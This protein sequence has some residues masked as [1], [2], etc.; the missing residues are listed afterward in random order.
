[1]EK[2]IAE[3]EIRSQLFGWGDPEV[4]NT[5]NLISS[6]LS[7]TGRGGIA[8]RSLKASLRRR[9]DSLGASHKSSKISLEIMAKLS[10]LL[11]EQG[12]IKEAQGLAKEATEGIEKLLRSLSPSTL[13][14]KRTCALLLLAKRRVELAR[15]G[16][17][18]VLQ[19]RTDVLGP[20]HIDTLKSTLDL[21]TLYSSQLRYRKAFPLFQR[22]A[23]NLKR[24]FGPQHRLTV[25]AMKGLEEAILKSQMLRFSLLNGSLA[26]LLRFVTRPE[27]GGTFAI[28]FYSFLTAALFI[29]YGFK[30]MEEDEQKK[31]KNRL[32]KSLFNHDKVD[33][34]PAPA[35]GDKEPDS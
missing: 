32:A 30:E 5:S 26:R 24:S 14:A 16:L 23:E 3:R 29:G 8:I 25:E 6:L 31:H 9:A 20:G 21:A 19:R 7:E 35:R 10:E 15:S 4:H 17:E 28:L 13:S 18:D 12:E 22:A 34:Q 11:R 2:W 27:M 33:P 1:L